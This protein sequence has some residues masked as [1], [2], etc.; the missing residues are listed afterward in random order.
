MI[1]RRNLFRAGVATGIAATVGAAPTAEHVFTRAMLQDAVAT[2]DRNA[3]R[4]FDNYRIFLPPRAAEEVSL[5]EM[6]DGASYR[7]R[8]TAWSLMCHERRREEM[9]K[10]GHVTAAEVFARAAEG[11]VE[12]IPAMPGVTITTTARPA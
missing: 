6:T 7:V 11:P 3:V 9:G 1:T 8:E 10:R 4:A 5:I 2:L 12:R